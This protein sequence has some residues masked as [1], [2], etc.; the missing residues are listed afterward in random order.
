MKEAK[1]EK[2]M[3]VFVLMG[4]KWIFMCLNPKGEAFFL[5]GRHNMRKRKK[6]KEVDREVKDCIAIFFFLFGFKP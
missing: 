2:V 3:V 1:R 5:H 4:L 6:M